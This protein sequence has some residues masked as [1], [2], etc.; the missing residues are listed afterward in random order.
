[1]SWQGSLES[2]LDDL[3]DRVVGGYASAPGREQVLDYAVEYLMR[4]RV[5]GVTVKTYP[6]YQ[7][8]IKISGPNGWSWSNHP[9]RW[10]NDDKPPEEHREMALIDWIAARHLESVAGVVTQEML[11]ESR[12][13]ARE[14]LR[15]IGG[16]E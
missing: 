3:I 11:D 9:D 16:G 15:E 4:E 12:K 13:N 8:A 14:I 6:E 1:M 2:E 7:G 5:P 10:V